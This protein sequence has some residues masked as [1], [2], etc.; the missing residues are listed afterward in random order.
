MSKNRSFQFYGGPKD[1]EVLFLKNAK[2]PP[3]VPNY[4]PMEHRKP[5]WMITPLNEDKGE[6]MIYERFVLDAVG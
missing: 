6:V 4:I 2:A 1:G 5:P 3:V